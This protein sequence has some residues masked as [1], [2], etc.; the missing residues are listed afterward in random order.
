[1]KIQEIYTNLKNINDNL[2]RQTN[3]LNRKY[4]TIDEKVPLTF[5]AIEIHVERYQMDLN[6]FLS[7]LRLEFPQ[8]KEDINLPDIFGK[9]FIVYATINNQHDI[10][11]NLL[12]KG[13]DPFL[14][15]PYG[16]SDLPAKS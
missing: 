3:F 6:T 5:K 14:K 1:M 11:T 15:D 16:N 9:A 2:S 12:Q 10:V 7:S 13:A 8:I 4:L